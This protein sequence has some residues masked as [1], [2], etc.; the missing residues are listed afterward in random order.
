MYKQKVPRDMAVALE[1]NPILLL[2]QN[3]LNRRISLEK[4]FE[5]IGDGS[6]ESLKIVKK[7][8]LVEALHWIEGLMDEFPRDA[9]LLS[10]LTLLFAQK[11]IIEKRF[12]ARMFF[13]YGKALSLCEEF[14]DAILF[15][16]IA[17]SSYQKWRAE[18]DLA[19]CN[20]SIA[21]I[22]Y[23]IGQ[24]DQA[25]NLYQSA[26]EFFQEK[27]MTADV[28]TCDM[29]MASICEKFGRL[30]KAINLYQS[31]RKI[32]ETKG[33]II[34]AVKC[35]LNM[36]GAYDRLGKFERALN[37]YNSGR[38]ILKA[39]GTET[40]IAIC[41]LNMATV[42]ERIEQ[43]DKAL[44]LY[45][46]ARRIFEKKGMEAD[47]AMCD[48]NMASVYGAIDHFDKAL[49][50][51]Q[52]ARRIFE[53]KRMEIYTAA[54]DIKIGVLWES[55]G[56]FDQALDHYQSARAMFEKRGM[57]ISTAGCDMNMA[58]VYE[59]LGKLKE[60]VNLFES[61]REVFEKKGME[62]D[63]AICNMDM[64]IVYG[65]LDQFDKAL[66]L[67]QSARRVFEQSE[68]EMSIAR[69]DI[70]MAAVYGA[71]DQFDKAFNLYEEVLKNQGHIPEFKRDS[72]W[73][74]G[75]ILREQGQIKEA[76]GKYDEAIETIESVRQSFYQQEV[77]SSFLESFYALYYEM[78]ESCLEQKDFGS[79]LEYVERVKSRNLAEMIANRDLMPKNVTEVEKREY[80]RFRFQIKA[81]VSRLRIERNRTRTIELQEG[82]RD[83]QMKHEA[84]VK[85]LRN[86]DPE[87]DP[88]QR[89]RLSH[90]D[91]AN[92]VDDPSTAL[93]ELFP[94]KDK[95]IAFV[96]SK[97]KELVVVP[98][99][100][101]ILSDL[102]DHINSLMG[103]YNSFRVSIGRGWEETKIN[104]QQHLDK[105]LRELYDKIFFKIRPHL[106]GIHRIAFI[107][108]GG[109]HLL[110]LHA[111]YTDNDSQRHYI[112]DD[113]TLIYA[114]SAKILKQCRERK[115][116]RDGKVLVA[117]A[118]P[119]PEKT[120]FLRYALYEAENIRNLFPGAD[121]ISKCTKED[122]IEQAK[123]VNVLHYSGHANSY[124]LVL[125]N[126]E[127]R[128]N[129][130]EFVLG[131][132]FENLDLP[133]AYLVTLS[134]CETG[135]TRIG[136]QMDEY[137]GL[138][139]AFLY[140]GASTVVSSLWAV[141]DITTSLLMR[142]MYEFIK[143]GTGKAE[144]LRQA[145][146]WLK[147]PQKRQDKVEIL[148][149]GWMDIPRMIREPFDPEKLLPPDLSRPYY[150]AGF[151][152]S[153]A[154]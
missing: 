107:P 96:V 127:E 13:V 1:N 47:I 141:S 32:F 151:I 121:L 74:M 33:M 59:K 92:I 97:D 37:L 12:W 88:D 45:Q 64:G 48:I 28:A 86:K 139:S 114:P 99:E 146:L 31:A 85:I 58:N 132:I 55:V 66:N 153:G 125:H 124:A 144:S 120:G 108:Y 72:L 93:V 43:F 23:R 118:N 56:Q 4:G 148:K 20:V 143:G 77:R 131:D 27:A 46:S 65:K 49:T 5:T 11:K 29:R 137:M 128:R 63:F 104:W 18:V 21:N 115:R 24:L 52:S 73:G 3:I 71:V 83:L 9:L 69:C 142:K 78:V 145:Q 152:C 105:V 80:E 126:A 51:S 50:L 103:R 133:E 136:G 25:F 134:A 76:R 7:R 111:M 10:N 149:E 57:E 67:F 62:T 16:R 68:M 102:M 135:I 79:A 123:K 53:K 26:K 75:K 147:D 15:L 2:A 109:F 101:Y 98:I 8:H 36:A 70:N 61:A 119:E 154:E 41:N 138:T 87:F 17:K 60:A 30:E 90:E 129:R 94:M 84:M 34:A 35:G 14:N 140:A 117:F 82:L 81:S 110:P 91:I 113:Y 89:V 39:K 122:I 150:W 112:V 54:C 42:Y 106:K 40:D 19:K 116:S 6:A 22:H 130:E 38:R 100:D 44:N 95:T